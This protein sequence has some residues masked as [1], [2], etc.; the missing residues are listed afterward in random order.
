MQNLHSSLRKLGFICLTAGA[1]V[2]LYYSFNPSS[3]N[4]FPRC[5]TYSLFGIY[6]PGCGS[7]RAL[8]QLLHFNIIEA[9]RF[10][11]LLVILFPLIVY[12]V[13]VKLYDFVCFKKT[14]IKLF[15][16]NFFTYSLLVIVILYWILR[17]LDIP[18]LKPN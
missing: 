5:P 12:G 8:H 18:I 16:N 3:S 6:C 14:E 1:F 17:N 13:L 15:N 4:L 9:F 10:N 7:Q 11:P 2:Y